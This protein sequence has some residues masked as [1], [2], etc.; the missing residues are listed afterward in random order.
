VALDKLVE[1]VL[2]EVKREGRWGALLDRLAGE[3]PKC[4][5]F[6]IHGD[7][8]RCHASCTPEFVARQPVVNL[9][10]MGGFDK[11][12]PTKIFTIFAYSL[13]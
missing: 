5:G 13:S 3:R 1:L 6:G 10:I 12:I 9:G 2:V 7:G 8:T 11:A 4:P